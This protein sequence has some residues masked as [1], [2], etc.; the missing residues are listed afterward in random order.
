MSGQIAVIPRDLRRSASNMESAAGDVAK[1]DPSKQV[2]K[3]SSA[4]PG[5]ASARR[6]GD[7]KYKLQ[8]RFENWP[9]KAHSYHDALMAAAREYETSD[10]TAQAGARQE[11]RRVNSAG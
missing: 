7:L 6:V 9:K 4:M 2:S 8:W 5:S 3:I 10:Q 11:E 1:A